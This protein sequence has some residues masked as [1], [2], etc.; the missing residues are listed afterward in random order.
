MTEKK[1]IFSSKMKYDGI[2]SFSGFYKFCY[3]YLTEELGFAVA[4]SKYAEKIMGD[5]KEIRIEWEGERKVTDYFKNVIKVEFLIM[6]LKNVEVQ[7]EGKKIQTN[8]GVVEIKTK[9]IIVSDY[10][11]KYDT[12]PNLRFFRGVYEKW[13]IPSTIEQIEDK[14]VSHCDGFLGEAKAYL[15]LEGKR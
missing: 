6:G 4:E 13:I 2:F 10:E 12:S 11:G 15:D 9:G 14:L 8:K 7:R 5:A 1:E 3:D